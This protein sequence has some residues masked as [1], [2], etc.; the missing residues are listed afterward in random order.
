M[1]TSDSDE[2][3]DPGATNE[4]SSEPD[5]ATQ[6]PPGKAFPKDGKARPCPPASGPLSF[7]APAGGLPGPP[8][9]VDRQ[10][11]G[12]GSPPP[13]P[14]FPSVPEKWGSPGPRLDRVSWDSEIPGPYN[15]LRESWFRRLWRRIRG[16]A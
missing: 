14:R 9:S 15:D 10:Q 12:Y 8:F 2:T 13:G 3:R 4:V 5:N 16:R 1:T 6:G 11:T 7:S